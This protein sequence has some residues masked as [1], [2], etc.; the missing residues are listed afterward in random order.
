MTGLAVLLPF[1]L[2]TPTPQE[3]P[4]AEL[5]RQRYSK[6]EHRIPMRDGVHLFTA[7]YRPEGSSDALPILLSRTPYGIRPYGEQHSNPWFLGPS[8]D[9]L[10]M[11]EEYVFVYQDVRGRMMSEG[12]FVHM[13]PL[14]PEQADGSPRSDSIDERTDTWDTIDWLLENVPGNNGR[15]G[16]WGG[17]YDGFYATC[18]AISGH[19]ALV[20]ALIQ[21]PQT[22]W[23]FED[24]HRN[25]ILCLADAFDFLGSWGWPQENPTS[26]EPKSYDPDTE[27]G[28]AFFL[29]GGSPHAIG[30]RHFRGEVEMWNDLIDHPDRDAFWSSR[31]VLPHLRRS[32][33]TLVVGGWFDHNNLHGALNLYKTLAQRSAN[34]RLQLVVGPWAHAAWQ[35]PE[36]RRLG[37]FDFKQPTALQY[38]NRVEAPFLR[39]TLRESSAAPSWPRVL[40]FDTGSLSWRAFDEWPPARRT[41]RN[42][43]LGRSGILLDSDQAPDPTA[44]PVSS[45][46]LMS[47]PEDPVR[48]GPSLLWKFRRPTSPST[49]VSS[50]GDRMSWSIEVAP[51]MSPRPSQARSV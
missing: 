25:G 14:V 16:V 51:W 38:R 28:Y 11:V 43:Y 19:P 40:V 17:S 50:Q 23:F 44:S 22:D 30:E 49:N 10:H 1:L 32:A 35:N 27:D 47:K 4:F 8:D 21:G 29:D 2:L 5:I 41:S 20:S 13:R 24:F 37:R 31:D 15:V 34:P 45:D 48:P 18:A 3:G 12:E 39:S 9:D 36:S 7:V 26:A 33:A 46:T 6:S 42:L